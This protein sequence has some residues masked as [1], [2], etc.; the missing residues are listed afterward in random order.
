LTV[1]GGNIYSLNENADALVDITREI[2]LE[3]I[4]DKTKYMVMSGDQ[5]AGRIHSV[6]IGNST[7]ESVEEFK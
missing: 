7:F 4:A 2:G 5:N 3:I 1:Q 6:R